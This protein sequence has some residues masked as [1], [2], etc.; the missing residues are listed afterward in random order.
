MRGWPKAM[1]PYP[2]IR[3]LGAKAE[4]EADIWQN[5]KVVATG[6]G[7]G[8][9]GGTPVVPHADPA[10]SRLQLYCRMAGKRTIRPHEPRMLQ[11][12]RQLSN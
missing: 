12:K 9:H 6:S 11:D 5:A 3:R 4:P 1:L 7:Y 2:G 10:T 8:E